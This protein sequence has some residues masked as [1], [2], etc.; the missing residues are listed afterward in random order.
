VHKKEEMSCI[1][2]GGKES[3]FLFDAK[4]YRLATTEKSFSVYKCSGCGLM[5]LNPMPQEDELGIFYPDD[6]Y[7]PGIS[8][9]EKLYSP[10]ID[11]C[12]KKIVNEI[13][14]FKS[15]GRSLDVGCGTGIFM[16]YF[17]REGFDAYGTDIS[18]KAGSVLPNTLKSKVTIG[19][20]LKNEFPSAYFDVITLKQVLEHFIEPEAVLKEVYRILKLDGVLYIEVPN[21][22]CLEARLFKKYWYNLE[23]PRHLY[24]FN[25]N[26]FLLFVEKNGFKR[27]RVLGSSGRMIFRTPLALV[28]SLLFY[29]KYK[30]QQGID[31]MTKVMYSL[32]LFPLL[33]LSLLYRLFSAPE[34][35]TDLRIIFKKERRLSDE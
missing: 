20:F 28:N 13:K 10:L 35:Q 25:L 2:C 8:L 34:K 27:I 11:R 22:K 6:Y 30:R 24:H 32:C 18:K 3:R 26:N 16:S 29:L 21:T 23:V 9:I 12:F 33:L 31:L 5:F 4:D 14:K 17:H 15:G 19:P 1:N 7:Q